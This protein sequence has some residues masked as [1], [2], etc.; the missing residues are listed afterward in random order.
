[1]SARQQVSR[2]T[3]L[4]KWKSLRL[5]CCDAS[6]S[7]LQE[8]NTTMKRLTALVKSIGVGTLPLDSFQ[9]TKLLEIFQKLQGSPNLL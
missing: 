7:L 2:G 8:R 3:V 1:M 9:A 5:Q 6:K 4:H